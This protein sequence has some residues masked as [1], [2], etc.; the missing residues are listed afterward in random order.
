MTRARKKLYLLYAKNRTVFGNTGFRVM[1]RFI[2]EV[3]TQFVEERRADYFSRRRQYS[4]R[5]GLPP[6]RR[7]AD[8]LLKHDRSSAYADSDVR[9]QGDMVTRGRRREQETNMKVLVACEF[10]GV[11]RDAFISSRNSCTL[12]CIS[13]MTVFGISTLVLM[14]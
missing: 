3:P 4:D 13:K 8:V 11:V 1:S 2:E 14:R 5:P 6:S 12:C 9:G 7:N 10:S